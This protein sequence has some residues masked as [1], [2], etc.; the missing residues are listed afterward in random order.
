MVQDNGLY[1][2]KKPLRISRNVHELDLRAE[3]LQAGSWTVRAQATGVEGSIVTTSGLVR[4]SRHAIQTGLLWLTSYTN[5]ADAKSA[6][7]PNLVSCS[8]EGLSIAVG[9]V[10]LNRKP[11]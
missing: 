10:V 2:E 1:E 7:K 11:N 8:N 3:S 5:K 6:H 4:D 9:H